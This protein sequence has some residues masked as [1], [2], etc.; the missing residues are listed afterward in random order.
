MTGRR[1]AIVQEYVPAY[2]VPLFAAMAAAA[3]ADGDELVVFAG[4]PAG[5]LARRN[6]GAGP[7][8]WLRRIRQREFK[9]LGRRLTLRVLPPAVRRSDLIVV[10]QA[11]RNLD[12]PLLLAWPW[13][14]KKVAMWGHGSDVVKTPSLLERA[15]SVALLRR[16]AW[17]FAYTES[18]VKWATR[19]GI[20]HSKTTVLR[21]SIDAER[22]RRDLDAVRLSIV[23]DCFQALFIGGLDASKRV[24][25][26]IEIA[27]QVHEIEPGFRLVVAGDGELRAD[28]SAAHDR[29]SWLEYRGPLSGEDK[30]RALLESDV[31]L[32][33]GRVG[34]VAVDSLVA[35]RPI[36]TL[37][38][39]LHA[40]EYGYLEPGETCLTAS[41]V[42]EAVMQTVELLRDRAALEAM[43]ERCRAAAVDFSVEQMARRFRSGMKQAI[44]DSDD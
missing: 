6:D 4:E 39:S 36:V 5:D 23:P 30:A 32:L 2:R 28:V 10:E 14:A 24:G 11:R 25:E 31:L 40:P 21:N 41:S 9:I 43:Q 20:D 12:V 8:P 38:S 26:L 37:S 18:G 29:Y 16:A 15:Y 42:E 1:F 7:Q 34:L 22:L 3:A 19:V 13:T 44:E 35:G 27:T 33:P 17:F